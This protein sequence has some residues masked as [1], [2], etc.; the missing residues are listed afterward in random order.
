MVLLDS[1]NRDYLS[2]F[3]PSAWAKTPAITSFASESVCFDNH[4]IC[5][6]PCMPARR[7]LFTGREGF[8]ERGWGPLEPFD[9]TLMQCLRANGIFCHMETDHYHYAELGGEGYMQAF[10]TWNLER[11]QEADPWVS[12]VKAP[13][14]PPHYGRMRPQYLLNRSTF[15]REEQ[16]PTPLTFQHAISW[17]E[18]N[19]GEDDF[20]LM[21]E[22]F[23]PHEPFDCPQSYLD[24]YGDDYEG[25]SYYWPEY[26][27]VS[28]PDDA[29]KHIKTCYAG[30]LSMADHW[31]GRFI[32][33]MK[34]LGMYEDTLII[35]TTDH[36]HLLGEHGLLAKN[37]MH[38]YQELA[39]IPL[40]IH[41]PGGEGKGRRV[42]ALTNALDIMPSILTHHGIAIPASVKGKSLLSLA[43]GKSEVLH[44]YVLYGTFGK[45][46]NVTDG[47]YTYYRAPKDL[48]NLPLYQYTASP[49]TFRHYL[50]NRE[51][52][53]IEMGR[54]LPYTDYPVMRIPVQTGA[55]ALEFVS[56]TELY[57]IKK[58]RE[59]S[60]PL[61]DSTLEKRMECLLTRAM[62]E[63]DAPVEQF[64]RLG[65]RK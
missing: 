18:D 2:A 47:H 4:W 40:C 57:D 51:A 32:E 34:S 55:K 54:F 41:M 56:H 61:F 19:K 37:Y 26:A 38:Q 33:K 65:L 5:S 39:H 1:L 3:N 59:E 50:G 25:K 43:K 24:L 62:T 8:L 35:F 45:A 12:R 64:E 16:Y 63:M 30:T 11:G 14:I 27:P 13:L 6:A 31:L 10:D 42:S 20:F 58:D 29:Q 36:G 22:G 53:A 60:H 7:D 46:V 48:S 21:V 52:L 17:L 44:D 28:E 49:T 9:C 23:D 15:T